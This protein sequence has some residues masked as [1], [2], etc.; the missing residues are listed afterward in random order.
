MPSPPITEAVSGDQ[1]AVP[2]QH[3]LRF[4]VFDAAQDVRGLVEVVM[5]R[6]EDARLIVTWW[7]GERTLF[8]AAAASPSERREGSVSAGPLE[9]RAVEAGSPWELR[10]DTPDLQMNLRWSAVAEPYRW[11]L[12]AAPAVT[13]EEQLGTIAGMLTIRGEEIVIDAVGQRESEDGPPLAA[14]ADHVI[15][16]RVFIAPGEYAYTAIVTAARRDHLF[17]FILSDGSTA[18]LTTAE[19]V[20][21]HAYTGGPPLLGTV[22]VDNGSGRTLR[23][24]FTRGAMFSTVDAIPS[25]FLTRHVVFP[26]MTWDRRPAIGQIDHWYTD[27]ALVRPHQFASAEAERDR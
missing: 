25:G 15:T 19:I 20:A 18:E 6:D 26:E 3:T 8:H 1:H 24:S 10:Y 13:H 21:A 5:P 23:Q 7:R 22:D 2:A 12:P 9:L 14:V 4:G 27:A 17:G 16:C 11:A